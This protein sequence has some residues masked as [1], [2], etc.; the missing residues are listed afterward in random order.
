MRAFSRRFQE[1]GMREKDADGLSASK[2]QGFKSNALSHSSKE[3]SGGLSS[4]RNDCRAVLM[5]FYR[6]L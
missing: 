4:D 1:R 6:Y 5:L 3:S 2:L